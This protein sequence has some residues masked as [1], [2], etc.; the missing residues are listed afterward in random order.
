VKNN[1]HDLAL[2][3]GFE[4]VNVDDGFINYE[5]NEHVSGI[6][7]ISYTIRILDNMTPERYRQTFDAI[8]NVLPRAFKKR[9]Y[10]LVKHSNVEEDEK[11]IELVLFAVTQYKE[12]C[13]YNRLK[14]YAEV[15]NLNLEEMGYP[16]TYNL[17]KKDEKTIIAKIEQYVPMEYAA[18]LGKIKKVEYKIN[19]CK[20]NLK[21][22]I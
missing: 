15:L 21:K 9:V 13:E 18:P 11:C 8:V 2:A 14:A 17:G 6:E 4:V 16:F 19:F 3:V 22:S 5:F 20:N 1:L 12:K 10:K 7:S